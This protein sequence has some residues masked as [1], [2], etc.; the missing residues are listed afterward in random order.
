MRKINVRLGERSYPILFGDLDG[1]SLARELKRRFIAKHVIILT[2]KRVAR[3]HL[4][5]LTRSLQRQEIRSHVLFMPDGERYKT[6]ATLSHLYDK[7]VELK[8]DRSTLLLLLGGGVLGDVGGFLAATYMRGLP[9]VQIPTS[10]VAQVDSS[11]GGKTAVDHPQGKNLI[12]AFYQ[13]SFVFIDVA[14]LQSLPTRIYREGLAEVIKYGAMADA[15]FFKFLERNRKNILA[16]RRRVLEKMV[17]TSCRIKAGIVS[18]DERDTRKIR[19]LLNFGHTF[20]HAIETLS[21]YRKVLHGEAVAR[22]MVAAS[23][24]SLILKKTGP[25]TV[26]RVTRL[27]KNYGLPISLPAHS[28]R[29]YLRVLEKDKK[30]AGKMLDFVALRRIGKAVVVPLSPRKLISLFL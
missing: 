24:L 4:S 20:G 9:Y 30:K 7:L 1:P 2:Q 19:A 16:R 17:S 23:L 29:K 14:C 12:G 25:K 28:A 26:E 22:G 11:V 3:Y 10:L 18:T 8:A 5:S 15:G 21:G 13:P 6:L 27:L